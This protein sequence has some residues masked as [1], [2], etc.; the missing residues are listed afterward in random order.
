MSGEPPQVH[1][2]TR[3]VL[4]SKTSQ[5]ASDRQRE[6]VLSWKIDKCQFV[7]L[8]NW[9]KGQES[10]AIC[11]NSLSDPCSDCQTRDSFEDCTVVKGVCGHYF[12]LH[13]IGKWIAKVRTC[14]VCN[15]PWE[16][17]AS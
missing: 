1:K 9:Q 10:C 17:A 7:Y 3:K 8:F 16:Q 14:P 11:K 13:C 5:G 6:D 2:P 15:N 12:H 4:G